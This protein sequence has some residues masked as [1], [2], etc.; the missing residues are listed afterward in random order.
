MF[1][2]E[3]EAE[4]RRLLRERA[5]TRHLSADKIGF[6][7]VG[8]PQSPEGVRECFLWEFV[9]NINNFPLW[10]GKTRTGKIVCAWIIGI[11]IWQS[12]EWTGSHVV[13]PVAKDVPTVA[14]CVED[15]LT[16]PIGER[17]PSS[18]KD[19]FLV[20]ANPPDHPRVEMM[21]P[22]SVGIVPDGIIDRGLPPSLLPRVINNSQQV[23]RRSAELIRMVHDHTIRQNRRNWDQAAAALVLRQ[24]QDRAKNG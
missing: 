11:G 16:T 21:I 24:Q 20:F 22:E 8:L 14:K 4:L 7:Q 3:E 10:L 1:T 13:V 15:F 23:S 9:G 5:E 2:V 17:F 12:I 6:S 18:R 19:R